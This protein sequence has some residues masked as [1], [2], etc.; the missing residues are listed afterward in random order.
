MLSAY[1][2]FLA[3]LFCMRLRCALFRGGYLQYSLCRVPQ[4]VVVFHDLDF[5]AMEKWQYDPAPNQGHQR[6]PGESYSRH[7]P[8]DQLA[9]YSKRRRADTYPPLVGL[10]DQGSETSSKAR[11][12]LCR[13]VLA[14][15]EEISEH[16]S[17]KEHYEM[18]YHHPGIRPEDMLITESFTVTSGDRMPVQ[19][20]DHQIGN[21]PRSRTAQGPNVGS[22]QIFPQKSQLS[23]QISESD[24]QLA[25]QLNFD[26]KLPHP[27]TPVSPS[28]DA[29]PLLPRHQSMAPGT[30]FPK[31]QQLENPEPFQWQEAGQRELPRPRES[32]FSPY[33]SPHAVKNR[34]LR[35]RNGNG[36]SGRQKQATKKQSE[37]LQPEEDSRPKGTGPAAVVEEDMKESLIRCKACNIVV[38]NQFH[39]EAHVQS[40]KHLESLR[41]AE[42]V[43]ARQQKE[44][45]QVVREEEMEILEKMRAEEEEEGKEVEDMAEWEAPETELPEELEREVGEKGVEPQPENSQLQLSPPQ[46]SGDSRP[47]VLS[48]ASRFP[49]DPNMEIHIEL[50]CGLCKVVVRNR[51]YWDAHTQSP[52]H[53]KAMASSFSGDSVGH[54]LGTAGSLAMFYCSVCSTFSYTEKMFTDHITGRRHKENLK[55]KSNASAPK[56]TKNRHPNRRQANWNALPLSQQQHVTSSSL[57]SKPQPRA[58]SQDS[59]RLQAQETARGGSRHA[60]IKPVQKQFVRKAVEQN[61]T[62]SNSAANMSFSLQRLQQQLVDASAAK[63]P[64]SPRSDRVPNIKISQPATSTTVVA[65]SPFQETGEKGSTKARG[66][67]CI[68]PILPPEPSADKDSA[69]KMKRVIKLKRPQSRDSSTETVRGSASGENR[70]SEEKQG[71]R[72]RS[73]SSKPAPPQSSTLTSSRDYVR[74][75]QSPPTSKPLPDSSGIESHVTQHSQ[76]LKEISPASTSVATSSHPAVARRIIRIKR[77]STVAQNYSQYDSNFEPLMTRGG[78]RMDESRSRDSIPPERRIRRSVTPQF[79]QSTQDHYQETERLRIEEGYGDKTEGNEEEGY[80]EIHPDTP[81]FEQ[82]YGQDF[83]LPLLKRPGDDR[84]RRTASTLPQNQGGDSDAEYCGGGRSSRYDCFD[85]NFRYDATPAHDIPERK[86][87]RIEATDMHQFGNG[88]QQPPQGTQTGQRGNWHEGQRLSDSFQNPS[89]EW[90]SR[91]PFRPPSEQHNPGFGPPQQPQP[92]PW[93]GSGEV[94]SSFDSPDQRPSSGSSSTVGQD[95]PWGSHSPSFVYRSGNRILADDSGRP[96]P[97][98]TVNYNHGFKHQPFPSGYQRL[99]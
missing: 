36:G 99:F 2:Y 33:T 44:E 41:Q 18:M 75:Q 94:L 87:F 3:M 46:V 7:F 55:R 90:T 65:E 40:E 53:Q 16:L 42:A 56:V 4:V 96:R 10:T 64:S 28:S 1:T 67:R 38:P 80:L 51:E 6:Q 15:N 29:I 5:A 77:S 49:E 89:P 66:E 22:S 13:V 57:H 19:R 21:R 70:R 86:G 61:P 59:S 25:R 84:P 58:S 97:I 32:A 17:S 79:P 91:L 52:L 24:L 48:S 74:L 12:A 72:R 35:S 31:R 76:A 68:T 88:F 9:P 73:V 8:D 43:K 54:V 50:R 69:P 92:Q 37:T 23:F 20:P 63:V 39:W 93:V 81:D 45:Q 27:P 47:P 82:Y 11:C 95:Q 85:T 78:S 26:A 62:S 60:P 83:T 34:R 71:D 30:S 14:S 98:H